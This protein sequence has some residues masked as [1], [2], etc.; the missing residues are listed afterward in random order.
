MPNNVDIF[1]LT[2][3]LSVCLDMD[4]CTEDTFRRRR[5]LV[6]L[7]FPLAKNALHSNARPLVMWVGEYSSGRGKAGYVCA[8]R[9]DACALARR[10]NIYKSPIEFQ[11]S[12]LRLPE[13][14][15]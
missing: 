15:L 3:R 10:T 12:S 13:V 14:F 4:T 1:L 7:R 11:V 6:K 9:G 2:T 5:V 8:L